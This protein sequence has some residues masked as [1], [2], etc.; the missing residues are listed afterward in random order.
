MMNVV[1]TF[2]ML[3]FLFFLYLFVAL[4]NQ[5]PLFTPDSGAY[6]DFAFN[7]RFPEERSVFYSFFIRYF[8][9]F[10]SLFWVVI[11]QSIILVVLLH[12][13][14][15]QFFKLSILKQFVIHVSTVILTS[16]PWFVGQIMPDIFTP[17][18]FLSTILFLKTND[19]K[20]GIIY[21]PILVFAIVCHNSNLLSATIMAI[22]LLFLARKCLIPFKRVLFFSSIVVFSWI[23]VS[24]VNFLAGYGFTPNK[25][26]HVFLMG[27]FSESGVLKTYLNDNCDKIPYQICS[28]KDELP[29][30]AWDFVWS[31]DGPFSKSGGWSQNPKEYNQIINATLTQPKYLSMHIWASLKA[32]LNQVR[33][34][35]IGDGLS[36]FD[37]HSGLYKHIKNNFPQSIKS[38]E[39][40]KQN[41]TALPFNFFNNLYKYLYTIFIIIA[42][43]FIGLKKDKKQL[44]LL[45][46]T[47]GF[48][49]I[50]AF[51]TASFANVLSRL[52]SRALWLLPF[53]CLIIIIDSLN[54]KSR[55]EV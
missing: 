51:T 23:M 17:I 52:N 42:L 46:T 32:T 38:F 21:L 25:M 27:K 4:Y 45:C 8:S 50:N 29:N 14:I 41:Q 7:D 36:S 18:L 54:K 2:L 30:H 48:I 20:W 26:S 1:K 53:I 31:N 40:S 33:L 39:A 10:N 22:L 47:M 3:F 24:Y 19:I 34:P 5:F 16:V 13:F 49:L 11:F 44:I 28:F 37:N 55:N 43:I 12:V 9:C 35:Y 15:N 6:I